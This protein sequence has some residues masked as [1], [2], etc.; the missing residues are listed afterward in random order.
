MWEELKAQVE[1]HGPEA[2]SFVI[3][4]DGEYPR[5]TLGEPNDIS[6]NGAQ[7]EVSFI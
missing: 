7:I 2:I 1:D 3:L 4:Q 6:Y 5:R